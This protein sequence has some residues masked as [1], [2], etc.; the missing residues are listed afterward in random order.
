MNP[1]VSK[2]KYN[3]NKM[4][5]LNSENECIPIFMTDRTLTTEWASFL[6]H[7]KFDK[8]VECQFEC[9]IDLGEFEYKN[10]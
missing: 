10:M 8:K 7:Y 1:S 5:E 3:Q 9:E 6:F 2:A 4:A